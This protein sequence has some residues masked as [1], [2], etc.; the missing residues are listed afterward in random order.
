MK[1]IKQFV[2]SSLALSLT[3]GLFAC[4]K[5]DDADTTTKTI[6]INALS[7]PKAVSL[8]NVVDSQGASMSKLGAY[9]LVDTNNI[10]NDSDYAKFQT[11]TFNSSFL[12]QFAV[13]PSSF[14]CVAQQTAYEQMLNKG[15]YKAQV[16]LGKCNQIGEEE[17]VDFA[18]V[19]HRASN[20]AVQYIDIR[21]NT[22]ADPEFEQ[23]ASIDLVRFEI[24]Q[25][26]SADY[27]YGEFK[28]IVKSYDTEGVLNE[29]GSFSVTADNGKPSIEMYFGGDDGMALKSTAATENS[30]GAVKFVF[31]YSVEG[32]SF[33]QSFG[34]LYNEQLILN[35][36]DYFQV[37]SRCQSMD[38]YTEK[39]FN[40]AL[41]HHA[42]G[43][44]NNNQ[45]TAGQRVSVD[46]ALTFAYTHET[47]ND[48]N[49]S[50]TFDGVAMTGYVEP[51]LNTVS[52][53]PDSFEFDSFDY[54][55]KSGTI[56]GDNNEFIVK[57]EFV[58]REFALVDESVC[59]TAG[60]TLDALADVVLPT[61][62]H[63]D[64]DLVIADM[65]I[66][67]GDYQVIVGQVQ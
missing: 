7:L 6:T 47:A 40:Y 56:V 55:L 29:T 25:N 49:N 38:E 3:L 36:D 35:E 54:A 13:L 17:L 62:I 60:L 41:F 33:T 50:E 19:S 28:L 21:S 15:L 61:Q 24:K 32:E 23:A 66:A 12:D 30:L 46:D 48:R 27:P 5:K 9:Q 52:F 34:Q 53:F 10:P 1:P 59:D 57:P 18:V 20:T 43:D 14:I 64:H 51:I 8:I 42:A 11:E 16:D 45:V 65:P 44:V 39:A 4:G 2:V 26:P 31:N 67:S 37:G 63:G 58:M 22:E